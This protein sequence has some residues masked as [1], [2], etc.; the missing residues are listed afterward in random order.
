MR[1]DPP[2][3]WWIVFAVLVFVGVGAAAVWSGWRS[4]NDP[5]TGPAPVTLRDVIR[6]RG[7]AP[8]SVPP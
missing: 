1:A 3:P 8:G 6:S 5:V 4:S 2:S 7:G